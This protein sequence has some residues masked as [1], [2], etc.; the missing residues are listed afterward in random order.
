MQNSTLALP[1]KHIGF[2]GSVN[3]GK[4]S[5]LNAVTMQNTALVSSVCG[6]TT[7][8]VYKSMEVLPL[9]PVVLIDTPGFDDDSALGKER[10]LR[11]KKVLREID[12]AVVVVDAK[13]GLTK[14]DREL[15]AIFESKNIPYITVFNKADLIKKRE[16][17]VE[18]SIYVSSL[19]GENIN[20]LKELLAR[21]L[22]EKKDRGYV[23]T[24][25]KKGDI[26]VLVTP[27]DE[28]APKGRIILP[29]QNVL[30]NILDIGA[31]GIVV[32]PKEL[33]DVIC[34]MTKKPAAVI[35]DSQAFGEVSKIVPDDIPL[36]SFSILMAYNKGFLEGA[37]LSAAKIKELCDNDRILIAEGC[38]HHRQ[39]NDIGTVKIPMWIKEMTGK[40]ISFD[41]FSGKDFP[42][43]LSKY[44]M[45]I[46]CGGCMITENEVS[47]RR[48]SAIEQNV[49]FTNYGTVIAYINGI[50]KK[51]VE[52]FADIYNKL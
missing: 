18:N 10:V 36:T 7:D 28:A 41:I 24:F 12:A 20:E 21:I 19:T 25:I 50:L 34:N 3:A 49:P 33:L 6:T 14:T 15:K 1:R 4:S 39:C 9:G 47:A 44:K 23:D 51:S 16:E 48:Q 37:V 40:D 5:L 13:K 42:E 38:T 32:Q 26:A 2:F 52:V 22:P 27:I 35:T 31:V 45:I 8:P 30:R 43:D 46:H 11:T 17:P 29:V